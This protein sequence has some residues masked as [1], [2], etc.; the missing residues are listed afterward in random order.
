MPTTSPLT[1]SY[2]FIR[3]EN[4]PLLA[5]LRAIPIIGEPLAALVQPALKVIVD[6][7]YGDPAHGSG[8]PHH[9]APRTV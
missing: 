3:T 1:Q 6:L 7:G 4:L 5:P 9:G 2:Y 8:N